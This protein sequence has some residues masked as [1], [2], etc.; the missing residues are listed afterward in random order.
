MFSLDPSKMNPQ[1]IAQLTTLIQD[2]PPEK[3]T[4]MQSIMHNSMAGFDVTQEMKHFEES[5]PSGFR[6]KLAKLMYQAHGSLPHEEVAPKTQSD[7]TQIVT[8]QKELNVDSARIVI[9]NAV[10]NGTLT[11]EDAEKILFPT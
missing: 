5:L 10:A 11:P 3:L 2:L 8:P 1:T 4:Q 6:E 7:T 9:L